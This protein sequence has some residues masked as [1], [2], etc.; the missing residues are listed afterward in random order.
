MVPASRGDSSAVVGALIAEALPA[1]PAVVLG[2]LDA[3]LLPAVVA[4][5]DLVVGHPVG[6]PGRVLH[7]T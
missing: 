2:E 4:V 1:G 7:Q 6:G 3:E 5:Q